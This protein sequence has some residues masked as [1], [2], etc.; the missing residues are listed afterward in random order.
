MILIIIIII[1]TM[2]TTL[3][4]EYN[5]N[6]ATFFIVMVTCLAG[7]I[8]FIYICC[9]CIL[10]C[11]RYLYTYG[12]FVENN[13]INNIG[14]SRYRSI[15]EACFGTVAPPQLTKVIV[16]SLVNIKNSPIEPL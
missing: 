5:K 8:P 11:N 4:I 7:S 15:Y 14:A 9:Y 6:D 3:E 12:E 16:V 13:N 10:C 2:N 1:K